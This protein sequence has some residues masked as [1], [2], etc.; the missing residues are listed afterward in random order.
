[1]TE[2]ARCHKLVKKLFNEYMHMYAIQ[3]AEMDLIHAKLTF[4]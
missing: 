4:P 1:M 2:P 3:N